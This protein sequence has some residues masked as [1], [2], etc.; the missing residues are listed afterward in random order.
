M[1]K[2]LHRYNTLEEFKKDYNE[3]DGGINSFVCSAGTFT[4]DRYVNEMGGAYFWKN[5]DKEL[6]T[7]WRNPKVG[8]W[9]PEIGTGAYDLDNNTGV[10]ITEVGPEEE[11]GEYI[12][13]WVSLTKYKQTESLHVDSVID[14]GAI[15][16]E[17][18]DLE[19]VGLVDYYISSLV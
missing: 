7:P 12:E 8:E 10:E 4:Y 11:P 1:G 2:Y 3:E 17:N 6:A 5:G 18:V 14:S 9:N 13:P 15:Q 16:W 19:Y